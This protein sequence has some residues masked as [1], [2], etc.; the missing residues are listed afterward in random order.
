MDFLR[1]LISFMHDLT[2]G[3]QIVE[4]M[5]LLEEIEQSNSSYQSDYI[6]RLSYYSESFT[7]SAYT[8]RNSNS[9]VTVLLSHTYMSQ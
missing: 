7:V 2:K 8:S 4:N 9:D 5:Q 3:H 6:L 1:L